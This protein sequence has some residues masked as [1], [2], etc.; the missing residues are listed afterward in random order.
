M[1]N[2]GVIWPK[3]YS[4]QPQRKVVLFCFSM[5]SLKNHLEVVSGFMT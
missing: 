2:K 3:D 5:M 1:E 4:A